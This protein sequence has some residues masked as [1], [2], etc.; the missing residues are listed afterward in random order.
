MRQSLSNVG[1]IVEAG[2]FAFTDIVKLTTYLSEAGD[3]GS[4]MEVQ[5][6]FLS[7]RFP[8]GGFP[9][10]TTVVAQMPPPGMLV[11]VEVVA[12]RGDKEVI[13]ADGVAPQRA[14]SQAI[15]ADDWIFL[16][17]QGPLDGNG[18]VVGVGDMHAQTRQTLENIKALL[19][20]AGGR[21][22]DVVHFTIWIQRPELYEPLNE[23]RVPFY[24][25]HFPKG[26][27]PA[28]SAI[29]GP[30]PLPD[31]LLTV[32]VIAHAGG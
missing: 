32:E 2:G 9:V 31:R 24:R 17:G 4:V 12:A 11:E 23:A 26:D 14:S 10:T 22:E 19:E 6:A 20:A 30:S 25:E 15:R 13:I 7:E 16:A 1:D 8:E 5:N 28:S 27:Y 21:F 29:V 18:G 3:Y